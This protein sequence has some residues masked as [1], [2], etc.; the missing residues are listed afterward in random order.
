MTTNSE[1]RAFLPTDLATVLTTAYPV[2]S[3]D[4]YFDRQTRS[5]RERSEIALMMQMRP[6]EEADLGNLYAYSV[7]IE[8]FR[9]QGDP[10]WTE[11]FRS[12]IEE[13]RTVLQ[14]AYHNNIDRFQATISR[15]V[16]YVHCHEVGPPQESERNK[17]ERTKI[18]QFF[19]L[20]VGVWES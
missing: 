4:I 18:S 8:L 5:K 20:E 6:I 1:L 9:A 7:L 17:E 15:D 11:T 10:Y 16:D 3:G 13:A 14:D 2:T 19:L 12:E